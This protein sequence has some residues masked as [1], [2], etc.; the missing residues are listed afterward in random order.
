MTNADVTTPT[1]RLDK[2]PVEPNA[3]FKFSPRSI[4][5]LIVREFNTQADRVTKQKPYTEMFGLR[6]AFNNGLGN[7]FYIVKRDGTLEA[8]PDRILV[9]N[10]I[11]MITENALVV[12]YYSSRGNTYKIYMGKEVA[13]I[14]PKSAA[15][16]L[17]DDD[18]A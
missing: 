1:L 5:E 8:L 16:L 11:P 9:R 10:I 4:Q 14:A 12:E 3:H 7:I 15:S 18:E 6:S 17:L 13:E 2:D